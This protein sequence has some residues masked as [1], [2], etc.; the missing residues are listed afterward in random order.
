VGRG[1]IGRTLCGANARIYSY[2]R[3]GKAVAGY[4]AAFGM[5]VVVWG[6]DDRRPGPRRRVSGSRRAAEEFFGSSDVVS[7]HPRLVDATRASS[8]PR[9]GH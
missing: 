3:L 6:R 4:G 7:L 2:G 5:D 9:P 8:R 1:A